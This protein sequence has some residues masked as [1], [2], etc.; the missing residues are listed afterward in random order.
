MSALHR[1]WIN[2]QA[3]RVTLEAPEL[4]RLLTKSTPAGPDI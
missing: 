2:D 4:R 3:E 1:E